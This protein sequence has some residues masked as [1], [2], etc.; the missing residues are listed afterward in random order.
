M[1]HHRVGQCAPPAL[2]YPESCDLGQNAHKLLQCANQYHFNT[3]VIWCQTTADKST[4]LL[5]LLPEF[6]EGS[7]CHTCDEVGE[8]TLVPR[9]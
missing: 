3:A 6:V 8:E 2:V 1:S 5:H 9:Y 4:H 7:T